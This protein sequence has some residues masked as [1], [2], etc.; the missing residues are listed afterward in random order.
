M[1]AIRSY[2]D[3]GEVD[4]CSSQR[5][6][7]VARLLEGCGLAVRCVPDIQGRLWGKVIVR[8]TSY[9]VCYTKLLRTDA[10]VYLNPDEVQGGELLIK[11]EDGRYFRVITSY[12][13]HY[14]K[15]YE[16]PRCG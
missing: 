11:N 4:G 5:L 9:N 10:R 1:Y 7:D 2:Y 8:I 14:T 12:S 15:L 3:L 13:I 16:W 6:S